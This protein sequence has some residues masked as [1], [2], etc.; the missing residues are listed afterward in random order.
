MA[1]V[2]IVDGV[3]TPMVKAG[4]DFAGLS[5]DYLGT[6]VTKE[7]LKRHGYVDVD[8]VIFGCVSQPHN[9][10]NIARVIALQ[11]GLDQSIPAYTVHRNCASGLTSMTTAAAKI[12]AGDIDVAIVGGTESMSGYP[13]I[14]NQKA[15]NYLRDLSQSKGLSKKLKYILSHSPASLLD[16][17]IGLKEGLTDPM[18]GMIMGD[19]AEV[20]AKKFGISRLSQDVYANSSHQ[21]AKDARGRLAEEIVSVAVPPKFKIIEQDNAIRENQSVEKLGKMRPYFDRRHGTV[22]IGNSCGLT[23]GACALILASE[24]KVKEWGIEPLGWI[25][26]SAYAGCRPDEMGIGP[27]Y[28]TAKLLKKARVKFEDIELTELNEAFAAQVIACQVALSSPEFCKNELGRSKPIITDE[29]WLDKVNVNGGAIA[30]GHPVGMTGAR[31]P[32]T[33]LKELRRRGK[34]LGLAT[35]CIGGGQGGAMLVEVSK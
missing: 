22:T 13:F 23:D 14:Y 32:L 33:L 26:K 8:E 9:K 24:K 35:L 18:T 12:K 5:A 11:S 16:P 34:N 17:I 28:A 15:C 7:L 30:L 21:R 2:A 10:Q 20:L 31:L 29:L 6:V 19:T 4:A 1:R 27:A 3:R 25:R